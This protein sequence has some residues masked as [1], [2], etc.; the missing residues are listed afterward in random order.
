[1]ERRLQKALI[2]L[3][4]SLSKYDI[5]EDQWILVGPLAYKANGF[6][7]DVARPLHLH[8]IIYENFIPWKLTDCERQKKEIKPSPKCKFWKEYQY[9]IDKTNYDF[10]IIILS[11]E[12]W[13]GFFEKKSKWIRLGNNNLIRIIKSEFNVEIEKDIFSEFNPSRFKK[14]KKYY[15]SLLQAISENKS[16]GFYKKNYAYFKKISLLAQKQHVNYENEYSLFKE[17]SIIKGLGVYQGKVK[18][19]VVVVNNLDILPKECKGKIAVLIATSAK[20]M[21]LICNSIG[22]VTNEGGLL[23]HATILSRELKIPCIVGTKIAT[24][25][26]QNGDKIE[27]DAGEGTVKLLKN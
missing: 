6:N 24:F 17:K 12:E 26:L 22:L 10:D 8:I 5:N 2:A 9:F 27:I 7:V 25:L 18:G 23:S 4:L 19:E 15:E 13:E 11:K 14:L 3:K 21:R 20:S 1:M 16:S